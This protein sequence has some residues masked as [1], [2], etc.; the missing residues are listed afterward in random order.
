MAIKSTSKT[1]Y[2]E[3]SKSR[4]SQRGVQTPTIRPN[5][6]VRSDFLGAISDNELDFLKNLMDGMSKNKKFMTGR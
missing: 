5:R 6:D 3:R 4:A 2:K 1:R